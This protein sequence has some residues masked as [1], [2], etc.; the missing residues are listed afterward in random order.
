MKSLTTNLPEVL[1]LDHPED[2][3]DG[4]SLHRIVPHVA[5]CVKGRLKIEA[6]DHRVPD[7]KLNDPSDLMVVDSPLNG[8]DKCP[9]QIRRI[10]KRATGVPQQVVQGS[11]R[12][13]RCACRSY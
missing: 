1:S 13:G 4:D 7:G 9:G 5:S 12:R 3:R 6:S 8:W 11:S 10:E 2:I